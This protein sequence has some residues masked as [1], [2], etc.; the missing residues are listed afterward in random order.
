MSLPMLNHDELRFNAGNETSIS[1]LGIPSLAG[2]MSV[3]EASL[4]NTLAPDAV[5]GS[6]EL[7]T[8]GVGF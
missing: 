2:R 7:E 3:S 6:R 5:R 4:Q 8:P 1:D